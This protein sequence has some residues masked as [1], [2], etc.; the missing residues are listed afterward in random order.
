MCLG[1]VICKFCSRFKFILSSF[2][3]GCYRLGWEV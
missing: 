1:F 3:L 2:G